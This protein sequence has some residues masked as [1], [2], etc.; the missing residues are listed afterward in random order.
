MSTLPVSSR[1]CHLHPGFPEVMCFTG[2]DLTTRYLAYE[3]QN[4]LSKYAKIITTLANDVFTGFFKY[5]KIEKGQKDFLL[6]KGSTPEGK[7][8]VISQIDPPQ[9]FN[10]EELQKWPSIE[11]RINLDAIIAITAE[12]LFCRN[13]EI[14]KC[15]SSNSPLNRA[16]IGLIQEYSD[17]QCS[18]PDWVVVDE[19]D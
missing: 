19:D 17:T 7:D 5:A 13:A 8:E 6:I 15:F 9:I 1:E 10:R 14:E 3:Q 11:R 4:D 2:W 12:C 16:M 18:N